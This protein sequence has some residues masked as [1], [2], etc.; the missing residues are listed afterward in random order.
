[1]CYVSIVFFLLLLFG[2][3]TFFFPLHVNLVG[4]MPTPFVAGESLF[5]SKGSTA[6]VAHQQDQSFDPTSGA[7]VPRGFC[8]HF[9]C[10]RICAVFLLFLPERRSLAVC[11][12]V[13]LC[14]HVRV[15]ICL[16]RRHRNA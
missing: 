10:Q 8:F 12:C 4:M 15:C 5:V 16:W 9:V 3:C 14:V 1:M 7:F 11:L 2:R 6:T 13:Y